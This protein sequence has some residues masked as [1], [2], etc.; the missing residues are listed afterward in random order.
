MVSIAINVGDAFLIDT[1]PNDQHLYIAIAPTSENHYLF[2][3]VTTSRDNSEI[4]CVLLPGSDMPDF[5]NRKS[6]VTY[7]YAREMST[8][9]LARLITSGSPIPKCVFSPDVVMRI[10]QGG[11]VSKRLKNKYKIALKEFLEE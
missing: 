11:L 1:P 8:E 5:I 2:V 6:V 4:S 9:E 10:Q 3:N 7:K